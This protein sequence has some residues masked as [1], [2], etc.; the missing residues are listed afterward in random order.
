MPE[1]HPDLPPSA[2]PMTEEGKRQT[3]VAT[4]GMSV[5]MY[6]WMGANPPLIEALSDVTCSARNEYIAVGFDA[7]MTLLLPTFAEHNPVIALACTYEGE[8]FERQ[9][10]C[11][12]GKPLRGK[13]TACTYPA[14]SF[15]FGRPEDLPGPN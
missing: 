14:I 8:T 3:I 7:S 15:T 2:F 6:K 5:K 4:G 12:E 1:R 9:V 13:S 11:N 10:A